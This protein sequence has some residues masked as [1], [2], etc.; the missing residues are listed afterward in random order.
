MIEAEQGLLNWDLQRGGSSG[1]R[2]CKFALVIW[3]ASSSI[4]R[5]FIEESA[6]GECRCE[7][8]ADRAVGVECAG[9]DVLGEAS[10]SLPCG[11]YLSGAARSCDVRTACQANLWQPNSASTSTPLASGAAHFLKDRCDGL[12]D[13]ARPGRPRTINDDQVA[14]RDRA[15]AANDAGR[16][17]ARSAQ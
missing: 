2:L 3:N 6:C 16:R 5:I 10:P 9:A 14:G 11:R 4:A 12:L 7:R 8:P 15:N 1:S 13:E 17:G